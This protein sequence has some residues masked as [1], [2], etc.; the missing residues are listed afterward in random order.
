MCE[1]LSSQK[2]VFYDRGFYSTLDWYQKMQNPLL[3]VD[4]K[5]DFKMDI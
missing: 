3:N 5:S 2:W 1:E 4:L